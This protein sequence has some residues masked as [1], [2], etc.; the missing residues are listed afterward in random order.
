M[1][2]PEGITVHPALEGGF[3]RPCRAD[4][5]LV[6]LLQIFR[7]LHFHAHEARRLLDP[8][9]ALKTLRH[10]LPVTLLYFNRIRN[11]N[12][13]DSSRSSYQP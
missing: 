7:E 12:H 4:F 9:G 1:R 2:L 5:Q 6:M 13:P 3:I 8:L 11:H 10:R